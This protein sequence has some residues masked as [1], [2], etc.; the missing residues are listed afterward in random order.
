MWLLAVYRLGR[1]EHAE[2]DRLFK[3]L[4]HLAQEADDPALLALAKLRVTSYYQGRF[5]EARRDLE[6]ASAA[7][8]VVQQQ[9]LALRYGMAPVVVGLAYLAECLWLAGSPVRPRSAYERRASWRNRSTI[10]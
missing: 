5:A 10:R 9:E 2:A 3:R 7:P 1:S 8:D 4:S 6:R